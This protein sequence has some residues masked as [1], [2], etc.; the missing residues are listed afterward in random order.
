MKVQ[1][2]LVS[3]VA[4]GVVGN[5]LDFIV[6]NLWLKG[7]YLSKLP[8]FRQDAP[9][10]WLI[11]ADFVGALVFLWVYDRVYGSFRAGV[12]GG[13]IFGLYAGVFFAFPLFIT[14]HLMLVGFP[15]GLAW[16]YTIYGIVFYMISGA[17]AG[18]TYKK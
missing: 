15:Y 13:L 18:A 12:Q 14:L 5:I 9:M 1:R 7:W 17:V 16:V 10:G 4:V 3:A 11:V 6:Q 8:L 2:L